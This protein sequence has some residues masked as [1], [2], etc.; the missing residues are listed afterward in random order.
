MRLTKP[1]RQ[2]IRLVVVTTTGSGLLVVGTI[3]LVL[4]LPGT[5]LILIGL[6]VL[7][8][9]HKWPKT[10][11]LKIPQWMNQ[12]RGKL[13]NARTKPSLWVKGLIGKMKKIVA[14]Y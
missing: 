3:C 6:V 9:E 4:P 11:L 1:T 12:V 10:V 8:T 2:R 5:P 13:P 14:R 7:S